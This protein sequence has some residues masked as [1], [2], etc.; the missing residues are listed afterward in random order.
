[1]K[2]F[3]T[4]IN[5]ETYAKSIDERLEVKNFNHKKTLC[6]YHNDGTELKLKHYKIEK[7]KLKSDSFNELVFIIYTEHHGIFVYTKSDLKETP[8]TI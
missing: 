3:K 8:K 5:I 1:M 6:V 4:F 7:V 2:E